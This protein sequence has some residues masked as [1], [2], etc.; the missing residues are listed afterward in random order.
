MTARLLQLG[1]RSI[2]SIKLTAT[3]N[4]FTNTTSPFSTAAVMRKKYPVVIVGGGSAGCTMAAKIS[5]KLGRGAVAVIEPA[6]VHYYQPLWTLIGAGVTKFD[7]CEKPMKDCLPKN[8][9]WIKDMVTSINP[10]GSHLVTASGDEVQYDYLIIATGIVPNYA[11]IKG[12]PEA[13]DVPGVCSNYSPIYVHKTKAAIENFP[14]TGGNAIFTFPNSPIKCP[15]APHKIMYLSDHAWRKAGKREK[16][17]VVYYSSLNVIF[18]AKKYADSLW[19]YVINKRDINVNLRH[20]LIEVKGDTKE[21]VFELLDHP[22]QTVTV[23]FEMLH[24]VPP[25]QTHQFLRQ[26]EK[27]CNEAGFVDVCKHTLRHN[28]FPN[29]F[30]LGDCSSLPTSKTAAAI[31]GQSAILSKTF[32]SVMKGEKPTHFYDG[33]TSCPLVTGDGKCILA[34]FDYELQPLESFPF[35][36]GKERFSMFHMKKDAIPF[37]YWNLMLKGLWNGPKTFRKIAHLGMSK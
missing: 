10:E 36:Q 11:A 28:V 34:E 33:Y 13:F 12:L 25:M 1:R 30:S 16:V 19:K 15:G 7:R 27:L 2:S 18:A 14:A 20:N 21:A 5:R 8:A 32:D 3:P 22:G 17:N 26:T 31:A 37:I 4:N 6:D 23:P 29:V 9:D 24:V 35:D